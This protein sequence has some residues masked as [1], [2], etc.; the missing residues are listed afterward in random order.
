MRSNSASS[1]PPRAARIL[2]GIALLLSVAACS[3]PLA[4][5]PGGALEGAVTPAPTDWGFTEDV[6]TIQLETN[7]AEPYSVNIWVAALGPALYVHA[8]ANRATWIANMEAD[9]NVRLQVEDAVYELRASRV[10]SQQEFDEFSRVYEEKYGNAPRNP[11]VD[12][13]YLFRLVAR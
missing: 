11:N 8:G 2:V 4:L 10:E 6:S 3:G 13:A 7:P 1:V 9:P 12:E 5:F